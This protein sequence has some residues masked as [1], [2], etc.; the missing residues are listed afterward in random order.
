MNY[1]N[2]RFAHVKEKVVSVFLIEFGGGATHNEIL[3]S[4][5]YEGVSKRGGGVK[6]ILLVLGNIQYGWLKRYDENFTALLQKILY[7]DIATKWR[8]FLLLN[9]SEISNFY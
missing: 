9:D 2:R 6:Y 1:R 5:L 4:L 3:K 7:A 8:M